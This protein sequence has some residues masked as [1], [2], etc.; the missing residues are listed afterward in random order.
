MAEAVRPER[1]RRLQIKCAMVI[2]ARVYNCTVSPRPSHPIS[3]PRVDRGERPVQ[4]ET[5]VL[6]GARLLGL[7]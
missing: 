5:R 3:V 7:R 2:S 4:S 6:A 1:E